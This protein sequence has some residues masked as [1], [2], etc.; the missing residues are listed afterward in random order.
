MYQGSWMIGACLRNWA[1]CFHLLQHRKL[2]QKA[3]FVITVNNGQHPH[4]ICFI[5]VAPSLE[6]SKTYCFCNVLLFIPGRSRM[7][8]SFSISSERAGGSGVR[9]APYTNIGSSEYRGVKRV[10]PQLLMW[11]STPFSKVITVTPW[12]SESEK[13]PVITRLLNP[14]GPLS[15]KSYALCVLLRQ[16]VAAVYLVIWAAISQRIDSSWTNATRILDA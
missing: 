6:S 16:I 13:T 10:N 11:D 3:I 7:K 14:S 9:E 2:I 5:R 15:N 4:L 1:P 12:S 8:R